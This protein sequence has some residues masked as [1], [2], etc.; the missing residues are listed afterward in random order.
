[1]TKE[2][3]EFLTAWLAWAEGGGLESHEH[4]SIFRRKTGLCANTGDWA[5]ATGVKFSRLIEELGDMLEADGLDTD[6]PFDTES[7]YSLAANYG[8]QHRNP[9]RLEWVR[10]K[11]ESKDA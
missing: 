1:M 3:R 2:M 8:T 6:Y 5:E 7:S 10:S 9:Y 4:G 11:L